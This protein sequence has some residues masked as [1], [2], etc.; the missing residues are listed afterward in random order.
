MKWNICIHPTPSRK[1]RKFFFFYS[2]SLRFIAFGYSHEFAFLLLSKGDSGTVGFTENSAQLQRWIVSGPEIARL[3]AKFES[4]QDTIKIYQSKGPDVHHNEQMKSV[5]VR[6]LVETMDSLRNTFKE[7]S[8]ELIV[9]DTKEIARAEVV[10]T[11]NTIEKAG[12]KQFQTFVEER[13]IKHD[14]EVTDII[15]LTSL[16]CSEIPENRVQKHKKTL[17]P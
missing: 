13:L 1:K 3:A 5:Q 11:V 15:T 6:A 10:A 2:S 14:K 7:D 4:T 12:L 17:S 8:K 16:L 9:P